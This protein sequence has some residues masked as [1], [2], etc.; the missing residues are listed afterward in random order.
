MAAILTDQQLMAQVKAAGFTGNDAA[1]AFAVAKAESGGNSTIVSTPNTDGSVDRG[2]FQINSKAW[3]GFTGWNDPAQN[4]SFAHDVVLK[5]Q[6]WH[7]WT[8]Y[9][10]GSYLQY[11]N[12]GLNL[13]G[14]PAG[15]T[16]VVSANP[17]ATSTSISGGSTNLFS[18]VLNK[19]LWLRVGI[20]IIGIT[21]L[22]WGLVALNA[23]SIKDVL[24]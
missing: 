13:I 7:A 2:L 21:A 8:A 22:I 15:N 23:N 1:I 14:T 9:N 10:N 5:E 16:A 11:L 19:S 17:G 24:E 3:P 18:G 6:G 12:Q 4:S 20:G